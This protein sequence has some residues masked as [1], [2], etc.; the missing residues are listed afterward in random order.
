MAQANSESWKEI[1]K[2]HNIHKHQF[3]EKPF[4]ISAEQIKTACQSF[5]KTGEKEVRILCTQTRREDRPNIF[6]E[7]GLFLL[8]VK[9]GQYNIIKG[10]GYVDIPKITGECSSYQSQLK[11]ELQTSK[12]GQSEM[13]YVD[14]AYATSLIKHFVED[15][16]LVLTIRGRKY[17]EEPFYFYVNQQKI[18]VKGVQT[19]VDAGYEGKDK[20]VLVEAKTGSNPPENLII[21]QLYY[22]FRKWKGT[23]KKKIINL[24]FYKDYKNDIYFLWQFDFSEEE[25][26]NSI[27]PVKSK[28]YKIIAY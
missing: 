13:Q 15:C 24:L 20:V 12:I 7:K 10:E 1:F 3:N 21:R 6:Q 4:E 9:N 23:T 18:E 2:T 25:Q 8:P 22:P 16:S 14:Y 11:F 19:E 5:K 28:K 26:Y 27:K 17:T